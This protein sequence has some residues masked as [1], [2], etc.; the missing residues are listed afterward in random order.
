M[1]SINDI[2]F[3]PHKEK[4]ESI[5]E[6]GYGQIADKPDASIFKRYGKSAKETRDVKACVTGFPMIPLDY[7][8]SQRWLIY[9]S[10]SGKLSIDPISLQ[11]D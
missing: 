2:I 3:S 10:R 1:L 9:H 4:R 8:E 11:E 6:S 5:Q 7:R